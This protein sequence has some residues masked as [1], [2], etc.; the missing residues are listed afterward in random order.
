MPNGL[1]PAKIPTPAKAVPSDQKGKGG[2]GVGHTPGK[3]VTG[4]SS[5][6]IK[7]GKV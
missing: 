7:S 2:E 6:G 4:F 1:K 3:Q 5:P